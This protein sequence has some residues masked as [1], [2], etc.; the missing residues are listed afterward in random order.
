MMCVFSG[1]L[2]VCSRSMFLYYSILMNATVTLAHFK[3]TLPHYIASKDSLT[4]AAEAAAAQTR[5]GTLDDD[6]MVDA[7]SDSG[8]LFGLST[9]GGSSGGSVASGATDS[10]DSVLSCGSRRRRRKRQVKGTMVETHTDY[11]AS[12]YDLH[13]MSVIMLI[14][15]LQESSH[16]GGRALYHLVVS[17]IH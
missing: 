7:I 12:L 13:K 2:H 17:V 8:S 9:G 1:A 14:R 15:E 3:S 11:A 10:G 6:D 4:T 5:P 16:S